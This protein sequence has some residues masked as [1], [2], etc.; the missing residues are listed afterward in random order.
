MQ[1]RIPGYTVPASI[2]LK[3]NVQYFPLISDRSCVKV[4]M[5]PYSNT[6]P[7]IPQTT[8]HTGKRL[9][10]STRVRIGITELLSV[11]ILVIKHC[12]KPDGLEILTQLPGD[13]GLFHWM[14][15]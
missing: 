12:F 4:W 10:P 13:R 6:T 7:R 14:I 11:P 3:L 2:F 1:V 5:A 9:D 15:S 8:S